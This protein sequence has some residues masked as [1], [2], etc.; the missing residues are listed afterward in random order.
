MNLKAIFASSAFRAAWYGIKTTALVFSL[1]VLILVLSTVVSI[2]PVV[3][4]SMLLAVIA[5]GIGILR[6]RGQI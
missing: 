4:L 6:Y 3:G 1:A 2:W 5:T